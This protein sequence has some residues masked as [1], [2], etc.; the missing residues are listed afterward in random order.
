MG[1]KYNIIVHL[2]PA[3]NARHIASEL[4]NISVLAAMLAECIILAS[5]SVAYKLG[6]CD[7]PLV[8]LPLGIVGILVLAIAFLIGR[9]IYQVRR[10]PLRA[11]ERE[12]SRLEHSQEMERERLL[13]I[14]EKHE[15]DLQLA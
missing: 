2:P 6:L 5:V 11:E 9:H 3:C 10:L 15:H 12:Q 7:M 13:L 1:K 4:T 8:I 14:R